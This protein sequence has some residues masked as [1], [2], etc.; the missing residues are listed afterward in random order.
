MRVIAGTRRRMRLF[1]PTTRAIK[2]TSDRLRETIFNI[3]MHSYGYN[4]VK[5]S[6]VLDLFAGTGAMGIEALSREALS[7]LFVDNNSEA[8]TLIRANIQRTHFEEQSQIW[9]RDATTLG[10]GTRVPSEKFDLVFVDPPYRKNLATMAL[11]N[12]VRQDL[13]QEKAIAVV[14]EAR[15]IELNLPSQFEVLDTRNEGSGTVYVCAYSP[16]S[17]LI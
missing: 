9:R 16:V 11:L 7:C 8:C 2:P 4:V 10:R 12:L 17:D 6:R 15:D 3:L 5:N 13:L 14:E 1:T